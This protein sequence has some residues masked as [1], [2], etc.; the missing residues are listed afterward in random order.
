MSLLN[1]GDKES[2]L[3]KSRFNRSFKA[4]FGIGALVAV[5]ALGSTLAASIN[6][7]SGTPVEFGQ[8]IA[9]TTACDSNIVV[10]PISN[11]V[12]GDP[13]DF[14]FSG[15][16]L[17]D[18][19][20]TDQSDSSPGCAGKSFTIKAFDGSGNRLSSTYSIIVG[21]D[22]FVSSDGG[23][24][25]SGEGTTNGSVTLTFTDA[26][27][28]A[29]DIYLVTLESED[30]GDCL[31]GSRVAWSKIYET[32]DP[33]RRAGEIN[34]VSGN[35]L[36]NSDAAANFAASGNA[37]NEI[38]YV[39]ELTVG[40]TINYADVSFSAWDG[41]S[42]SDLQVPDALDHMFKLQRNVSNLSVSSNYPGVVNGNCL[43]GRLEIWPGNYGQG[44]S[45]LL[46]QG[47]PGT[48]DFDDWGET[49][50]GYGSF[51]VHNLTNTETVLAWNNHGS[52]NPDVGFGNGGGN[53][54]W[55]FDSSLF[56]QGSS[57]KLS[58]YVR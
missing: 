39:M 31:P 7:N 32:I 45:G 4:T 21:P 53:P 24:S 30:Y 6:L 43:D 14:M 25:S 56:N 9:Q 3:G 10:T 26:L 5:I 16:T 33:T 13:G 49:T 20:A 40:A 28:L 2:S 35:G 23:I 51:Q 42:V 47:N 22:S 27:L 57:W 48:Y 36:G 17:S 58:I 34:Y 55:T 11:F 37:I 18:I 52:T 50:N 29:S 41:V 12:N 54:D 46:P 44:Y 38:R 15:I 1:F 19:D 8:G